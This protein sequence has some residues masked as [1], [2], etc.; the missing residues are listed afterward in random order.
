MYDYSGRAAVTVRTEQIS[1]DE[2][3]EIT[4]SCEGKAFV[5]NGKILVFYTETDAETGECT[6]C[7]IKANAWEAEIKRSGAYASR[8]VFREG[9]IYKTVY[10]T[11][12]GELPVVT[13]TSKIKTVIN[14]DGVRI[15]LFYTISVGGQKF[16]N[17]VNIHIDYR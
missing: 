15:K 6:N 12:F 11:R 3:S 4:L 2:L 16:E 10:R 7:S 14:A 1:D 9:E 5:K 13:D 17:R 8:L